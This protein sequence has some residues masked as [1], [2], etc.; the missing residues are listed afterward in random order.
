[1]DI[2]PAIGEVRQVLIN[3]LKARDKVLGEPGFFLLD[4]VIG[5]PVITFCSVQIAQ[6]IILIIQIAFW[7]L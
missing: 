1:M 3:A 6:S 7:Q 2:E 4:E 5:S